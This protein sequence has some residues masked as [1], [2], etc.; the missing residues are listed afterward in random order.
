MQLASPSGEGCPKLDDDLGELA[1][2]DVNCVGG[3]DIADVIAIL[4]HYAG[5]EYAHPVGCPDIG[6][7]V[8]MN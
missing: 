4:A 2:G 7:P 5:L 8:Q 6:G 3:I 1:W